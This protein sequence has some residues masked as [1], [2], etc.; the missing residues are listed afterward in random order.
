MA[1]RGLVCGGFHLHESR[2]FAQG[3]EPNQD[4]H[5]S[6]NAYASSG[7]ATIDPDS[8]DSCCKE[9]RS[10]SETDPGHQHHPLENVV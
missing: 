8:E 3:E 2:C 5:N 1:S 7:K 6:C 4:D 10:G 9:T